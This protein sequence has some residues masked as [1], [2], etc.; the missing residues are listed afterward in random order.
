M[1]R[2]KT[3]PNTWA[4]SSISLDWRPSPPAPAATRPTSPVRSFGA[5][6]R[7]LGPQGPADIARDTVAVV[8]G[9]EV[10]KIISRRADPELASIGEQR[11]DRKGD[12]H[13]LFSRAA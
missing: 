6:I 1:G 8:V 11:K 12:T 9:G 5:H 3:P 2:G 7:G 10:L 13:C 4:R